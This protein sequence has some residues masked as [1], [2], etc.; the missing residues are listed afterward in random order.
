MSE[1][2][3]HMVEV[4]GYLMIE[5]YFSGVFHAFLQFIANS[6]REYDHHIVELNYRREKVGQK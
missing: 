5:V 1:V 2:R 3:I 6:P 4:T